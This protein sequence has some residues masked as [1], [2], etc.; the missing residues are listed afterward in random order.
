MRYPAFGSIVALLICVSTATGAGVELKTDEQKTFYALGLAIGQNLTA[1]TLSEAELE[2]V[3]AGL[4]D[5]VL[6]KQRQVELETWGPKI[7]ELQRTRLTAAA[8]AEQKAGQAF[9]DKASAEKGATK[10]ASGLIISTIKPGTGLTPKAADT[11]KVH[12]HGTLTDGSVFDS[13]VQRGEPATFSLNGVIPCF[14]E[15]IQQMK[16]G[17]KSRLV[18]PPKLAYGDRG[19]PPRIKPGATLVFEVELLEI[20]TK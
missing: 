3:K 2:L 7:Q 18:C 12:Y 17:G 20:V 15:G 4:S 16:V 9:L 11:V 10:T 1:F 14:S 19:A 6:R 8:A 13:S 5:V